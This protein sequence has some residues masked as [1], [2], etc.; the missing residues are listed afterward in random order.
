MSLLPIPAIM[1]ERVALSTTSG[2]GCILIGSEEYLRQRISRD[3]LGIIKC[4]YALSP[5]A[6][7]GAG[8]DSALGTQNRPWARSIRSRPGVPTGVC[9]ADGTHTSRP[10]SQIGSHP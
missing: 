7:D 2:T 5:D 9:T 6:G 1:R 8:V 4:D 3:A 10:L